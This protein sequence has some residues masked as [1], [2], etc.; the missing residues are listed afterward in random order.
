MKQGITLC[1]LNFERDYLG[2]I[3]KGHPAAPGEGGS[4]ESGLSFVIRV[5]FYCFIRTQGE[6][7]L[8]IFL[9]YKDLKSYVYMN[10]ETPLYKNSIYNGS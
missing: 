7:G 1:W 8:S 3:H 6:G 4:A 2:A 9:S 10:L 5:W